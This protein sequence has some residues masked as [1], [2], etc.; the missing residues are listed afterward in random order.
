MNFYNLF[1]NEL[2]VSI[3]HELALYR[4]FENV[5]F[6]SVPDS[7]SFFFPQVRRVL[8][9]TD[10]EIFIVTDDDLKY[11]EFLLEPKVTIAKS[12]EVV[13]CG[14]K[15]RLLLALQDDCPVWVFI[16]SLESLSS[17]A[18]DEVFE[19]FSFSQHLPIVCTVCSSKH[20]NYYG[21][22]LDF[23]R[24]VH[25]YSEFEDLENPESIDNL[26]SIEILR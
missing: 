25:D 14:L 5:F 19:I 2:N 7:V 17:D 6:S 1:D 10:D 9:M 21:R 13:K 23:C 15:E 8:E 20:F 11:D 18:L 16:D 3:R 22:F 12:F 26:G 24:I 4:P